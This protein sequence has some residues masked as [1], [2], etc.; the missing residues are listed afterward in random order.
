MLKKM[1]TLKKILNSDLSDYFY[2]SR[3]FHKVLGGI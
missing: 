2:F 3:L 1:K